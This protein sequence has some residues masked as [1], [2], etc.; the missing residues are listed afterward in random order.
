MLAKTS[1]CFDMFGFTVKYLDNF[2]TKFLHPVDFKC[3]FLN[4]KT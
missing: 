2:C 4:V 1:D 3:S